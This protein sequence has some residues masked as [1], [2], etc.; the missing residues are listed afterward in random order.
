MFGPAHNGSK[1]LLIGG[2]AS[3]SSALEQKHEE[4]ESFFFYGFAFDE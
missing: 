4:V 1:V 2:H 3:L